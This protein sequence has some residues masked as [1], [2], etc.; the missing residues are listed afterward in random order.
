[1]VT[2]ANLIELQ[3]IVHSEHNDPHHVLG[4]HEIDSYKKKCLAVRV[5]IPQAKE[6]TLIE[7]SEKKKTYKFEKIHLD[8][9]F[10][11]VLKTRTKRFKY[12]L[13]VTGYD[14]NT[15]VMEDP[16][17]FMP[18][19]SEMDMY[20]FGEGNHY[21]IYNKLGAHI[22]EIDGIKGVR[23]AIWAPNAKRVSVIGDFN[24]WD[25]RRN[26]MRLLHSS[27]IWEL[28]YPDLKVRD[29]YKFE[30]KDHNGI[31]IEKTDPYGNFQE[32]RP[33]H[34]SLVFDIDDYKWND[35]SWIEKRKNN[36]P[37]D[38]PVNIYE[39]HIGSWKRVVEDNN[40]FMSYLEFAKEI[41]PYVKEMG[42]THIELMP[43]LEHPFDGSWGYQVTGY[44]APTSRYGSPDEFMKFVDLCH[45]NNIGVI[46]DWVPA[47]FPKDAH[48]LA[49]FDGTALY[50]HND[51][52]KGEHPDWGT[53]IFNYGRNEVKNFLIANALFWLEKFHL[54][55][56]RVDA[57]ASMLYLDYG[58]SSGQW[59]PNQY[60]GNEN[61]EA[62]EFLKHMN[63]IVEARVPNAMM[64]AEESTAWAGVSRPAKDNG[65]GFNLK[66]NM[67]WMNDVLFYMAKDPVHRQYHHGSLTFSLIYAYTENFILVL[68]HDEVVHGKGSLINKM[69]GDYWQKFANL[70]LLYAFMTGHPGKKLLFMGG[71]FA[72]FNEWS[73]EKSIDWMLLDFEKHAKMQEFVKDLNHMYIKDQPLWY[74]D[75]KGTGFEWIDCEDYKKSIISF[76]RIGEDNDITIFV[77]NFTPVTYIEFRLGVPFEGK[78]K[79]IINSDNENY[80][81]S[82]IIN[83]EVITSQKIF[84]NKKDQSIQIKL[85]PLGVSV[86]KPCK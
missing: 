69:P 47:H 58:K 34:S 84:W 54:D 48:G 40:R 16:Y 20:L 74:D 51:S 19:I 33:S 6:V 80:G 44:Y 14:D 45:Q 18:T 77:C 76:M 24:N 46:L 7:L 41:I 83:T 61:L 28:F 53:L 73:E 59:I 68:S 64:I 86:I 85:P 29:K 38:G 13:Q 75:F 43:I 36:N 50:E 78:Y 31:V 70:R 32:L 9:F 60:G 12:Q 72:Q 62:V 81:G 3:K 15:W 71:E 21:E 42:Y 56:L 35:D 2:T 52:R 66:W 55:G 11:C 4:M 8:G 79:E 26:P 17:R 39:V 27:G 25:G 65:L 82:G 1:M 49:R 63:S 57:V 10:E 37:L 67:G 5:F 30:I 23:F 22:T